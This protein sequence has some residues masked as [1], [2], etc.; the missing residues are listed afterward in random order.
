MTRFRKNYVY[1]LKSGIKTK[2]SPVYMPLLGP[3]N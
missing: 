2:T 3:K 1:S